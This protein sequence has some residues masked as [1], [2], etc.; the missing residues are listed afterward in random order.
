VG[1]GHTHFYLFYR[2]AIVW[3]LG[4]FTKGQ[5]QRP[6][7][8]GTDGFGFITAFLRFPLL[9]SSFRILS[10]VFLAKSCRWISAIGVR[11]I[12]NPKYVST[13]DRFNTTVDLYYGAMSRLKS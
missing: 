7:G 3:Y 2:V 11:S 6:L 5:M 13:E 12:G 4:T 9:C 10:A 8:L 1:V